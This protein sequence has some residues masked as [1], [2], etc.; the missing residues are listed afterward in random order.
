MRQIE[1]CGKMERAITNYEEL[2]R[3]VERAIRVKFAP[4]KFDGK[5]YYYATWYLGESRA[6]IVAETIRYWGYLVRIDTE[7]EGSWRIY[8]RR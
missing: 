1:G 3:M 7:K 4:K 5:N 6:K 2:K 8:V